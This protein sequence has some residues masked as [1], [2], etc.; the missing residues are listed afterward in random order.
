MGGSGSLEVQI[1]IRA[2]YRWRK[3]LFCW[4]ELKAKDAVVPSLRRQCDDAILFQELLDQRLHGRSPRA[5]GR[6]PHQK[7]LIP[8]R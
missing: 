2:P 1:H 6:L 4:T 8:L 7:R 3:I 5:R